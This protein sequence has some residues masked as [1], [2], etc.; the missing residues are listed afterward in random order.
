[1]AA[2]E[3]LLVGENQTSQ[4]GLGALD[5]QTPKTSQNSFDVVREKVARRE[6]LR[7]VPDKTTKRARN[8]PNDQD[9][10]GYDVIDLKK[11]QVMSVGS[12]FVPNFGLLELNSWSRHQFGS[13]MGVRW[14]KFFAGQSPDEIQKA[15]RNHLKA[16]GPVL[17]KFV[18]RGFDKGETPKNKHSVGILR[19]MVGPNYHEIRDDRVFDRIHKVMGPQ[20]NDMH[21]MMASFKPNASHFFLVY[22]EPFD[23]TQS[24][25][26]PRGANDTYFFGSRMGNSEVG[27]RTLT[28]Q[29]WFVKFVCSNGMI[30]GMEDG[31]LL[32]KRH[33]RI[34]DDV[35]D[36]AIDS[37]FKELPV[38]RN[39]IIEHSTKLHNIKLDDPK[40][41][42]KRF[43][44]GESKYLVAAAEKAWE[45][46]GEP[47]N[48]FG[49][50]QALARVAVS[51]RGN[52]D[53]Q[54]DLEKLAG[55]YVDDVVKRN[56]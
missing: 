55:K 4:R 5:W 35:L 45:L 30:T 33:I 15:I 47:D 9:D 49:V 16:R 29:S 14:N 40:E 3:D 54:E 34:D 27:G 31:P 38:R 26:A 11:V 6:H 46:E 10:P 17:A 36:G 42:M 39:Q 52:R 24:G 13:L 37:A 8:I 48:A 23:A 44:R 56:S 53:K 7:L 19:G 43:L 21:F 1:M 32:K 25:I 20:L 51:A 12:I 2:A 18:A 22:N 41:E 28:L 50:A